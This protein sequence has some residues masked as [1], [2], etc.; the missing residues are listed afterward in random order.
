M[1]IHLPNRWIIT[2]MLIITESNSI[3]SDIGEFILCKHC[4][5]KVSME[6][7]QTDLKRP[8]MLT[9][10]FSGTEVELWSW[11]WLWGPQSSYT[12]LVVCLD[13]QFP[14]TKVIGD[15]VNFRNN[16]NISPCQIMFHFLTICPFFHFLH[17]FFHSLFIQLML[18]FQSFQVPHLNV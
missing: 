1:T 13:G 15:S 18:G 16:T 12:K 14:L 8:K 4:Y 9:Y 2:D 5:C 11:C 17:K 6:T 3:Y 10:H 7:F